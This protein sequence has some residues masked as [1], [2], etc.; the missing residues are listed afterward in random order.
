MHFWGFE[1]AFLEG[2][3]A[4]P[5]QVLQSILLVLTYLIRLSHNSF[6]INHVFVVLTSVLFYLFLYPEKGGGV[7][8]FFFRDP[9]LCDRFTFK[10]LICWLLG[11]YPCGSFTKETPVVIF[12]RPHRL[13][14]VIHLRCGLLVWLLGFYWILNKTMLDLHK[15]LMISKC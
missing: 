7:Q 12:F 11:P 2:F 8:D 6:R 13:I 15:N 14:Y 9:F 10:T 1:K 3:L 4:V 5:L